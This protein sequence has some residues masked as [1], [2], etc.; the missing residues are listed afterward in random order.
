[1]PAFRFVVSVSLGEV[2]LRTQG[3]PCGP[4]GST[5]TA[6]PPHALPEYARAMTLP[7]FTP[8]GFW[9][10]GVVLAALLLAY[11]WVVLVML[12]EHSMVGLVFLS[13]LALFSLIQLIVTIMRRPSRRP[14]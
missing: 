11:L 12:R 6:G 1:M 9:T 5:A 10:R 4:T 13:L 7:A 3:R 14:R 2:S 8:R